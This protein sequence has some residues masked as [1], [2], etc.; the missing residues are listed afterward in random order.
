MPGYLTVSCAERSGELFDQLHDHKQDHSADEGKDDRAEQP[1][2][3]GEREMLR[4]LYPDWWAERI[5]PLE[6]ATGCV[7]GERRDETAEAAGPLCSGC[8][9]QLELRAA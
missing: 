9:H 6:E 2:S 1:A 7:W 5:G 8:E 3:E 4:S